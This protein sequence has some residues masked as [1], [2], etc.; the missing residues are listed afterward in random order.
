[1]PLDTGPHVGICRFGDDLTY[2]G[3]NVERAT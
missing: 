1:M 2:I 3:L